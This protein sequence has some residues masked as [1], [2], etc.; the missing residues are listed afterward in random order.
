M[1]GSR[2]IINANSG[3]GDL[4]AIGDRVPA[5]VDRLDLSGSISFFQRRLKLILSIVAATVLAGLVMTMLSDKT[6]SAEAVV[7]LVDTPSSVNAS[8]KG[9]NARATISSEFVDTQVEIINSREMAI[10]VGDSLGLFEGLDENE[11][12]DVIEEL[13][14]NVSSERSG[15]S[16]AL[17]IVYNAPTGRQAAE[18]VN[19]FASQFT[20]WELAA[21][22]ERNAETGET[23]AGRLAGLRNQAQ[24]DMQAL[25][26]YRIANN[27]LSTSGASLTEQEISSYNQEVTRARAEA[28]EDQARLTTA[29]AQLRSGSTGE[30][31]GEALGSTVISSLRD[32]EAKVGGEVANL[33]ARYGA[34][35]P[36]LIRAKSQLAEIRGQIQSEITRVVS[37]LEAKR[38]V[39]QQRLVSLNQSLGA[40]R[41]KLSQNNAAMVGLHELERKAEASQQI[42]ETYLNSYKELL[43]SEGG[44][45]PNARILTLADIPF[46]PSSPNL[47]LNIILSGVI[48]L[49]LGILAAYVAEA[50]FTGL[51]TPDEVEADLGAH[52]L[53]SI[54]LLSS[55]SKTDRR[56]LAAVRE[57][58]R[59]AFAESFRSLRTS[60]EQ[61]VHGPAQVIAITSALPK[62]GKTIISACLSQIVARAGYSTLLID[63]DV[64]K[65]GVTRLLHM[66]SGQPG[67]IDVL[68]GKVPLEAAIITGENGLGVLPMQ[69]G[70]SDAEDLLTDGIFAELIAELR[71]KYDQIIMDLPPVLP[72]AATRVMA[73]HADATVMVARWRSTSKPA[74]KVALG[75]LPSDRV[76]VVGLALSQ[77][78]IRRRTFFSRSD[79]S[80]YYQQ[81]KEYYA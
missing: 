68:V 63:C 80:F 43:A 32:E 10:R 54:P 23:L 30:D 14:T 49:G 20:N 4:A 22:R 33:S 26:Q 56:E 70:E 45:R 13:K 37:N 65:R 39:S 53:G 28:A 16:Y 58:P 75:R 55:V 15:N 42:Y 41:G 73:S 27:L 81:Y 71:G 36:Q 57:H 47:M 72:V 66:E 29:L 18:R 61:A 11:R 59:S 3:G 76:N 67:L 52:F 40:A 35:H 77:V 24:A 12:R 50:L 69:G 21:I 34:R 6:Y 60:I 46:L 25:Q 1:N 2:Q 8:T 31:V 7:T 78:D 64:R 74:V 51:S 79:P 38:S 5:N 44:E 9:A 19:E 48:G 17:T 62:E